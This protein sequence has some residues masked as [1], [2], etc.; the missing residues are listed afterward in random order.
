MEA[1]QEKVKAKMDVNQEE[2]RATVK[3]SQKL[4]GPQ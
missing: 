1:Y 2:M 3:A 4:W